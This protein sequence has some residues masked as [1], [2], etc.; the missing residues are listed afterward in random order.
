MA[1][2]T[3]IETNGKNRPEP[4]SERSPIRSRP[5]PDLCLSNPPHLRNLRFHSAGPIEFHVKAIENPTLKFTLVAQTH[6]F[7]RPKALRPQ[8]SLGIFCRPDDPNS[9]QLPFHGADGSASIT[10]YVG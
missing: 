4:V 2:I 10:Q 6:W 5:V 8:R 1:Q 3:Q 9:L 7:P